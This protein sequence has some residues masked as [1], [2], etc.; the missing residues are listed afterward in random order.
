MVV[1]DRGR[2]TSD[3][4]ETVS[5]SNWRAEGVGDWE[6]EDEGEGIDMSW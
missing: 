3:E 1:A 2:G 6:G 5:V 4:A